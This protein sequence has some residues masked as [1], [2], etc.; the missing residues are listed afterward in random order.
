[1]AGIYIHI[2]FCKQACSYCDFH[3]STNLKNRSRIIES[4]IQE[5]I[6]RQNYLEEE[7]IET[8]YFGGGTPSLLTK[9]ELDVVLNQVYKTFPIAKEVEVCLEANPDDLNKQKLIDLNDLEINRL[10]IGVQS[11]HNEDLIFMN[12]AHNSDEAKTC[13]KTAQ[14]VGF[15]NISID[16]IFGSQT[17]SNQMWEENLNVFFSLDI[18]HLSSYSLTLEEKTKLD[19]LIKTGKANKLDED[20]NFQQY[21][22]LQDSIDSNG[23]EQYELSN[24]CKN[25]AI[26]KHNTSYWSHVKYLGLGPSAHSFNLKERQWNVSNN[27]LYIKGIAE[28]NLAF[29]KELLSERDRYHD[30]LI[31]RLRTKWGILY[32]DLETLFSKQLIEHFKNKSNLINPEL[33]KKESSGIK[34]PR[35]HLFQSDEVIRSLWLD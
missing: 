5:M 23:F 18:P 32:K 12:R 24:Y 27:S 20:K 17:T 33:V 11:F 28:N 16:L 3:F 2:P 35:Q 10:S 25:Q 7:P 31:T 26:S 9:K 1:M 21:L 22:I 4:I 13:I 19:Y 15:E 8:I 29:E 14:D 34:I 30:Y 6:M